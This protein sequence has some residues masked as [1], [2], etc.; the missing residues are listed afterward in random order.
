MGEQEFKEILGQLGPE[1]QEKVRE[2]AEF[3]LL[4]E[5]KRLEGCKTGEPIPHGNQSEVHGAR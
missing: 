1:E 3:L 5:K 2:F 4:R